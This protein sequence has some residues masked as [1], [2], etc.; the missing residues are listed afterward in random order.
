MPASK[1]KFKE[2]IVKLRND[3]HKHPELSASEKRTTRQICEVLKTLDAQ[4]QTFA[5]MTGVVALFK[6]EKQIIKNIEI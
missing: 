1:S 6:G 2:W 3:F 4:V 5:D